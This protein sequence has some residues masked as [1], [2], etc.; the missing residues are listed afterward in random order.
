MFPERER[1]YAFLGAQ[2]QT[3]LDFCLEIFEGRQIARAQPHGFD[4]KSLNGREEGNQKQQDDE[5]GEDHARARSIK[6]TRSMRA[7][8]RLNFLRQRISARFIS[9]VS[10]S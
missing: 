4:I 6:A 8:G 3:R 5:R 1:E 7:V 2:F 10:V 9:P